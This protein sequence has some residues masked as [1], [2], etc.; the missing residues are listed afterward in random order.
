MR[1]EGYEVVQSSKLLKFRAQGQERFTRSKTLGAD[2]SL[3]ALRDRVGKA[4]QPRHKKKI[5]LEKDTRINLLMDIQARLQGHGPGLERWMKIH[6]LKEAAKTLNYLTENGIT[7]YDLLAEKAEKAAADF[8]AISTSI[9]QTEHR[10]EQIAA[11]KTHIINYAKTRDIYVA[12]RKKKAADKPAFRAAHETDLLLH[13]AAKR[14]F[15]AQGVKKLPTVKALQAEYS[16]LLDKKKTAYEDYK[17]LRQENQELQAVKSN[18]DSLLNIQ[19][20][21]HQ[22]KEK[23]QEQGR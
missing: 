17:R 21:E 12:Y 15:D 20:E 5:R 13:E 23:N 2:Y 1:R 14:A 6:N 22:E 18:V 8:E 10:M 19:K 3:E 4:K 11:L 7:D 9:K 16:A